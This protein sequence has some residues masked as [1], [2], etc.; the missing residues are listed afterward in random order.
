MKVVEVEYEEEPKK[1]KKRKFGLYAAMVIILALAII[2]VS[3]LLIFHVQK[4]E[5]IGNEYSSQDQIIKWVEKDKFSFNSL[6]VVLKHKFTEVKPLPYTETTEVSM[7]NPWTVS[8]RVYEKKMIGYILFQDKYVYFDKDGL[9]VKVAS[10]QIEGIPMIEGLEVNEIV[11]YDKLPVEDKEIFKY[12]LDVT[13]IVKKCELV[14]DRIV[15]SGK[16]VNL[17]FGGICVQLGHTNLSDRIVQVPPILAKLE[18]QAG[19]L[20][21]ENFNESSEMISFQRQESQEE[22]VENE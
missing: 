3:F 15:C 16:D 11:L 9:V 6:Y 10:E 5:V 12:I 4:V 18:G 20:H 14:P 2:A 8:V 19:I 13:Q 22:S 21:L 7:K 17:Y 1:K